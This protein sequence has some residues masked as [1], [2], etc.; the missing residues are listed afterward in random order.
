[1]TSHLGPSWGSDDLPRRLDEL[2]GAFARVRAAMAAKDG[3]PEVRFGQEVFCWDAAQARPL[4]EH[5]ESASRGAAS[6]S[7]SSASTWAG[8]RRRC[9]SWRA[10]R[11]G[12]CWW[13]HPER[14]RYPAGAD[15][16]S[17]GCG[18]GATSAPSSR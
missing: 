11:G 16:R 6:R 2:K 3:L 9:C 18:A 4:L 17:I 10:P 1:M 14:Y 13:R 15:P 12:A 7:S 8:S 5:P